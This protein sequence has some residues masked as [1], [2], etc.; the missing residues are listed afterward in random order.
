[1]AVQPYVNDQ[2]R[3]GMSPGADAAEPDGSILALAAEVLVRGLL[4]G[5]GIGAVLMTT[6]INGV[7]GVAAAGVVAIGAALVS[8]R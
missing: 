5:A 8:W 2:V 6:Q 7:L 4:I 1:M 3:S